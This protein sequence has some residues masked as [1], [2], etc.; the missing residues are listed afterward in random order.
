[1]SEYN[2]D[3]IPDDDEY[4]SA[5]SPQYNMDGIP[6]DDDSP[7]VAGNLQEKYRVTNQNPDLIAT[8]KR[9]A[10]KSGLPMLVAQNQPEKAAKLAAAPD[11]TRLTKDAPVTARTLANDGTLFQIAHDDHE[12]LGGIERGLL[13]IGKALPVAGPL[14]QAADTTRSLIEGMTGINI[15]GDKDDVGTVIQKYGENMDNQARKAGLGLFMAGDSALAHFLAPNAGEGTDGWY[16]RQNKGE[17]DAVVD[18]IATLDAS[19]DP[20][21]KNAALQL[22]QEYGFDS[23]PRLVNRD[24][25]INRLAILKSVIDKKAS[26]YQAST[27][28][29]II[30]KNK[31]RDELVELVRNE[32][33][34]LKANAAQVDAYTVPWLV[35]NSLQFIQQIAQGAAASYVAGPPGAAVA[36]GAPVFG[37]EYATAKAAGKT[38]DNAALDAGASALI[39]SATEMVGLKSVD[40]VAKGIVPILQGIGRATGTNFSQEQAAAIAGQV[41]DGF[42]NQ[43]FVKQPDY[44]KGLDAPDEVK[45]FLAILDDQLQSGVVGAAGGGGTAVA[46]AAGKSAADKYK[47][48]KLATYEA[49]VASTQGQIDAA[50]ARSSQIIDTIEKIR[51]SKLRRRDTSSLRSLIQSVGDTETNEAPAQMLLSAD[52]FKQGGIDPELFKLAVP[53]A[54]NQ[55]DRAIELDGTIAIDVGELANITDSEVEQGLI[56][57]LKVTED[58]W[59]QYE[60]EL[61]ELWADEAMAEMQEAADEAAKQAEQQDEWTRQRKEIQTAYEDQLNKAGKYDKAA[62]KKMAFLVSSFYTVAASKIAKERPDITPVKLMNEGMMR[63]TGVKSGEGFNQNTGDNNSVDGEGNRSRV[64]SEAAQDGTGNDTVNARKM[65]EFYQKETAPRGTFDPNTLNIHLL[66]KADLS[67]FLHET[68]H[69]FLEMYSRYAEQSAEIGKDMDALLKSFGVDG[70]DASERLANWRAMSVNEQRSMHEQFAKSFEQ[71]LFSGKAP[72]IEL[73]PIF[74]T[75]RRWLTSVYQSLARFVSSHSGAKLNPDVS[76]VMDRMLATQEQIDQMTQARDARPLFATAD[77]AGMTQ[78]QWDAYLQDQIRSIEEATDSLVA[79]SLRDMKWLTNAKNKQIRKLQREAQS[80]RARVQMEAR[81]AILSRPEY[82]A[83]LALNRP[84]EKIEKVKRN[85]KEVDPSRDGLLTAIAKMGGLNRDDAVSTFGID[86]ADF[87]NAGGVFSKPVLRKTGGA[88]IEVMAERLL[89]EGYLTPD[90]HGKHDLSE[91]ENLL[92]RAARGDSIYSMYADYDVLLHGDEQRMHVDRDNLDYVGVRL[93]RQDVADMLADMGGGDHI[94]DATKMAASAEGLLFQAEKTLLTDA[95]IVKDGRLYQEG[96]EPPSQRNI[97]KMLSDEGLHPDMVADLFGLSSGD[98]LVRKL[99]EMDDPF[100]AIDKL[101]DKIMLERH[102]EF[103]DPTAIERMAEAAIH[104]DARVRMVATELAM[105]NKAQGGQK[106]LKR[107]LDA[108]RVYAADL[109]GGQRVSDI[110]PSKHAVDAAKAGRNADK[111]FSKGNILAA[112]MAKRNQVLHTELVRQAHAAKDEVERGLKYFARVEKA[113]NKGTIESDYGLQIIG[114]LQQYDLRKSV[115]LLDLERR[116]SLSAWM[117]KQKDLGFEPV[118]PDHLLDVASKT[119]YK[120]MTVEDFRTLVDSVRNIEHLGRLKQ[121]LLTA[122]DKRELNAIGDDISKSI[123]DNNDAKAPKLESNTSID[124]AA[125]MAKGFASMHRK[126]ANIARQLDGWKDGGPMWQYLIRPMN[127]AGNREAVMREQA[128]MALADVFEPLKGK[129]LTKKM[130]IPMIADSLSYE[131]R[132][133]VALNWGNEGNR[134]RLLSGHNWGAAEVNAILGTLTEADWGFVQGVWD[135]LNSYK[136]QIAEQEKRLKGVEPD[137]VEATPFTIKTADGKSIQVKGGYYPIKYDGDHSVKALEQEAAADHFDRVRGAKGKSKT[138]DGFT[139][140]RLEA[141]KDR[142]LRLDI[143]VITQHVTEVTHRLAFQDWVIDANRILGLPQVELAIQSATGDT[144][145]VQ[146]IRRAI[147]DIAAGDAPAQ[148]AFEAGINYLRVGATVAGLGW[149]VTTSLLQPF[150][151]T[152]SIVRIGPKWVAKGLATW[153]GPRMNERTEWVY[154]KSDFMRLRG[155]TMM[156]EMSEILNSVR[157]SKMSKIE[158]TYFYAIQ[159]MQVVADM[160]TWLGAY[161]KAMAELGGDETKAVELADQAVLDAQGGGQTKDLARIQRGGPMMK[162]WTN[163]YSFFNTT[164]NLSREVVGRTDFSDPASVGKAAVDFLLL[165]SV[166]AA[167][168]SILKGV[169]LGDDDED[170]LV[171]RLINDQMSYLFGTMVGLRELSAAFSGFNGYSGPA[172][173]RFFSEFA[174]LGKQIRQG[175]ADASFWKS[176]N[177]TAGVLL[178][179]PAGQINKTVQGA[180]ALLDDET[181]NPAALLFG[182]QK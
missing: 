77:Q 178:H 4:D 61:A 102:S 157:R 94:P 11:W 49:K 119:H 153:V 169:I 135:H 160:P 56:P 22:A 175:E 146:E 129:P 23:V 12:A 83:W 35:S 92:D 163:F 104:N 57:H 114:L 52:A 26:D 34:V 170:E 136:E 75:F 165:Y 121:K 84:V 48:R 164:Y 93:N 2:L 1:M 46:G 85:K 108:A 101:T 20:L 152:Q 50:K 15:M 62:N 143:D 89:E 133:A 71:Y 168:S 38:D 131:G 177:A 107:I 142:K 72:S 123:A 16:Y 122:K 78:A 96:D 182:H 120:K 27:N 144:S 5:P 161:E 116:E 99:L 117:Q 3:G 54:A 132:L 73:Q 140:S 150:G 60:A 166:P 24:R 147:E 80:I 42:A 159:K 130:Y 81:R 125:K 68:G 43:K 40:E 115:S 141:V 138:R 97:S 95:D 174:K 8:A 79:R 10:E 14:V 88:S 59:T 29:G 139:K 112:I 172:G 113:I 41:Y 47:E 103:T 6:D 64:E 124:R 171:D 148:N 154:S 137:W 180:S 126:L 21:Q 155:K 82:R 69:F 66:E 158:A 105:L 67:T 18:R 13:T 176:I 145:M 111:E 70:T 51:A 55:V 87:K 76:A 33:E 32:D 28:D 19:D 181:D 156:R 151:L 65:E 127:E 39:E 53:S 106:D 110:R 63:V 25:G 30:D 58:E 109:I 173:T 7:D 179:Y 134:Q 9:N 100:T 17:I 90:A 91:F 37:G 98:E 86:P 36:F 149:N 118:I 44:I 128:T 167:M 162:L 74:S 31:R 45:Q